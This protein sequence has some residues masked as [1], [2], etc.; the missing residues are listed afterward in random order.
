MLTPHTSRSVGHAA[1]HAYAACRTNL[2][3]AAF[4]EIV[5]CHERI[6]LLKIDIEQRKI[7]D[8][9]FI[10]ECNEWKRM[11][12]EEARNR[13]KAEQAERAKQNSGV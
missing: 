2:G 6:R 5:K 1:D 7:E 10:R 12:E 9:A 8:A 3:F 13:Q 11:C 4:V